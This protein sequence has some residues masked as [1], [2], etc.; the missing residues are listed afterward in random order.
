MTIQE[1]IDML[2]S[3]EKGDNF[4]V[5]FQL[6]HNSQGYTLQKY[7]ITNYECQQFRY[8]IERVRD[9]EPPDYN[10]EE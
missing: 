10:E 9:A 5:G 4:K 1:F 3:I 2:F 7:T 8:F 6:Q